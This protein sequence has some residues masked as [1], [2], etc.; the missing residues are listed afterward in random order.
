MIFFLKFDLEA[1][2]NLKLS[3]QETRDNL[4]IC[5]INNNHHRIDLFQDEAF[6]KKKLS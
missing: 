5:C 6:L 4:K 2:M 1:Y 3:S